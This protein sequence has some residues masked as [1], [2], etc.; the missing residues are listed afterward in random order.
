MPDLLELEDRGP[1]QQERATRWSLS[2]WQSHTAGAG[3]VGHLFLF[4]CPLLSPGDSNRHSLY[5]VAARKTH[6]I[7]ILQKEIWIICAFPH[8]QLTNNDPY[9]HNQTKPGFATVA[10]W[11]HQRNPTLWFKCNRIINDCLSA[12]LGGPCNISTEWYCIT[13]HRWIL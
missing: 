12:I 5:S 4:I 9:T 10:C 2:W 3:G 11:R 7:Q 6:C 8:W 1:D 13:D